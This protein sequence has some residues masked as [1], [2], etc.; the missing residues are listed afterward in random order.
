[1]S[2]ISS[3]TVDPLVLLFFINFKVPQF[4]TCTPVPFQI[5]HFKIQ[6]HEN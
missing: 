4:L 5:L 1:M 3:N 6:S 2:L